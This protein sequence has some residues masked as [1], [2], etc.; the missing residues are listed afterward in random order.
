MSKEELLAKAAKGDKESQL[1]LGQAYS[2]GNDN[3][4][5]NRAEAIKWLEKAGDTYPLALNMLVGIGLGHFGEDT[6]DVNLLLNSFKK[7]VEVHKDIPAM[8]ALGVIY[9]GDPNSNYVHFFP[10]LARPPHHNP[11]EGFRLIE[12]GIRLG[13]SEAENPLGYDEY[14]DACSAYQSETNK[15]YKDELRGSL[16]FKEENDFM[17]ALSKKHDYAKKALAALKAR[18]G[19]S[20]LPEETIEALIELF[21]GMVKIT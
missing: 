5:P 21:E 13:E 2:F 3:F 10:E 8:I 9:T 20:G 14:G 18:K 6:K 19:T 16:Y 15:R 12:E 1:E 4:T 7:L 17:Q 11:K